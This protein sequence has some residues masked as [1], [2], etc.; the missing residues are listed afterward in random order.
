MAAGLTFTGERF[1]PSCTGEIAYEH[2]HRYAFARR[3]TVGKRALDAACGEGYGTA[4]LGTAAA[5][6]VGIDIDPATIAH[7]AARYGA[8]ERVRFVR[9]SCTSLPFPDASFDVAVSFETIEHLQA[10]D[11]P[12][13]L[14]EFSRVLAPDGVL[15]I[16][17]PNKRLYSDER[18]YANEF[19]Y[20]ELYRDGLA[21]LLAPAFP[22]QRWH[23]QGLGC[24]S[25]IWTEGP[26]AGVEAWLAGA[27]GVAPYSMAEG[28][29]FIVVAARS[30]EALPSPASYVSLLTDAEDSVLE[31]SEHSAREVLRLDALLK[32]RDASADRQMVH[33]RHLESLVADREGVVR[34]IDRRLHELE[35]VRQQLTAQLAQRDAELARRVQTIAANERIIAHR[36]SFRW[37]LE[38]P[39]LRVKHWL[40]GNRQNT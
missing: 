24:W 17:S 2:W 32:E 10:S 23:H 8:R 35:A 6:S 16:S 34:D 36:Q 20:H 25:G 39:W 22:A 11:Q 9:G 5:V 38:L 3:F 37:W 12:R 18:S 30:P 15:I 21:R 4:L 26:G 28:M 19:H 1:L 14:A 13:M 29:Y 27:D 7:A 40:S 33:V 31:R